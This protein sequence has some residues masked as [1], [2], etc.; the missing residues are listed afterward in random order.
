[1]QD[2]EMIMASVPRQVKKEKLVISQKI[3][4]WAKPCQG[5]V[6]GQDSKRRRG[7]KG[8][9]IKSL[10]TAAFE[11]V[12]G[13][14]WLIWEHDKENRSFSGWCHPFTEQDHKCLGPPHS[15]TSRPVQCQPDKTGFDRSCPVPSWCW[16]LTRQDA[17][18]CKCFRVSDGLNLSTTPW[19]AS[20]F[21]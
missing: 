20:D 2:C 1:M 11:S 5:K 6:G 3:F 8:S 18:C 13:K 15:F 21:P 7:L 19:C 4:L 12:C 10:V 17:G 14:S 16:A 9:W